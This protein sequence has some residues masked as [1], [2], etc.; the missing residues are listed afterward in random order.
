MRVNQRI[1]FR[2]TH[3][4]PCTHDS[5]EAA[6]V[7]IV[8]HARPETD[9]LAAAL[10]VPEQPDRPL[11]YSAATTLRIVTDPKTL[12]PHVF[13]VR[14]YWYLSVGANDPD[15]SPDGEDVIESQRTVRTVTY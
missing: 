10:D 6:C 7:E 11:H 14:Q 8:V 3:A 9:A 1:Q 4:V 13:D 5:T 15:R 2:Y 12:T